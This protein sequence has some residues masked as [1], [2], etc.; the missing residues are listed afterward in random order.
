MRV[1]DQRDLDYASSR[2]LAHGWEPNQEERDVQVLFSFRRGGVRGGRKDFHLLYHGYN[3]INRTL[4]TG[5]FETKFET[6]LVESVE[7]LSNDILCFM[8]QVVG[9]PAEPFLYFGEEEL[10]GINVLRQYG[11]LTITTKGEL[12]NLPRGFP[13]GACA[14]GYEAAPLGSALAF[15][16]LRANCFSEWEYA[17]ARLREL[18]R[19]L[20]I[21]SVDAIKTTVG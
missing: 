5:E 15:A 20:P 13:A 1:A 7:A 3:L 6:A 14:P 12:R 21:V 8:G 4:D 17:S 18:S 19:H 2:V 16:Y 9:S 10:D 11:R